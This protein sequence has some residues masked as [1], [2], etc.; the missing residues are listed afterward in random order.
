MFRRGQPAH[1]VDVHGLHWMTRK[2]QYQY[3]CRRRG[4]KRANENMPA[5]GRES[6]GWVR[7]FPGRFPSFL[8]FFPQLHFLSSRSGCRAKAQKTWQSCLLQTPW[9]AHPAHPYQPTAWANPANSRCGPGCLPLDQP[10]WRCLL[11]AP[12]LL[13]DRPPCLSPWSIT[14]PSWDACV[15][16][17]ARLHGCGCWARRHAG[18]VAWPGHVAAFVWVAAA[19]MPVR[20]LAWPCLFVTQ[21]AAAPERRNDQ[22]SAAFRRGRSACLLLLLTRYC[23]PGQA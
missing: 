19:S 10:C 1:S 22:G 12:P 11:A 5:H 7:P 17:G 2:R 14:C 16:Q 23:W 9:S 18:S 21:Q 4:P 8:H 15:P 3:A 6:D 20:V 13:D